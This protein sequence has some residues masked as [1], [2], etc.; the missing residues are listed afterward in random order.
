VYS[1]GVRSAV[2]KLEL[3]DAGKLAKGGTLIPVGLDAG[4]ALERGLLGGDEL[5]V[6]RQTAGVVMSLIYFP[7]W[8]GRIEEKGRARIV[9]IDGVTGSVAAPNVTGSLFDSP[10]PAASTQNATVAGFRPLV[11]PNCGWDLPVHADD[12]IFFCG[13]CFRAWEID[14]KELRAIAHQIASV[15]ERP[16]V[17]P[18]DL[19]LPFWI[20]ESVLGEDHRRVFV[21]AFRY[22]Q[23]RHLQMLGSRLS[24]MQPELGSIREPLSSVHGAHYDAA[25]G[26]AIARFLHA[27]LVRSKVDQTEA[28]RVSNPRLV[29]IPFSRRGNFLFDPFLGS[30]LFANLLH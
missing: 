12:V 6:S 30:N 2:L 1:L 13:S 28:S 10:A 11:C 22:R 9:A 8:I 17:G 14:G 16:D 4:T 29:W 7:F 5:V 25:D 18:E 19:Y 15:K 21:P 20:V 24:H 27:G 3:F 23:L 26:L